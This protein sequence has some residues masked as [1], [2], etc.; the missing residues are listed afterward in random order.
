VSRGINEEQRQ[1]IEKLGRDAI[2]FAKFSLQ[3]FGDV[4]LKN[5]EYVD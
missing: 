4:V 1:E 3:L 2:E 5:S